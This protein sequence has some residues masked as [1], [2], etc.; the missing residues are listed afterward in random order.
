MSNEI[1]TFQNFLQNALFISISFE[2]SS[3]FS[4]SSVSLADLSQANLNNAID[5]AAANSLDNQLNNNSLNALATFVA[6][7]S[8]TL[9]KNV[10][11]A[12][13]KRIFRMSQNHTKRLIIAIIKL[14]FIYFDKQKFSDSDHYE[15]KFMK[16][17]RD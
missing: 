8:V 9:K 17:Y 14:A 15:K 7:L 10:T 16:K 2:N 1:E 11:E 4:I 5:E 6:N 12:L 3:S 13:V